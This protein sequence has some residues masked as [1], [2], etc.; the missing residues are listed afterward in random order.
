MTRLKRAELR[1]AYQGPVATDYILALTFEGGRALLVSRSYAGLRGARDQTAEF[2]GFCRRLLD[3]ASRAAPAAQ[4]LR[5]PSRFA[6]ALI[7]ALI[8]LGAGSAATILFAAASGS[9]FALGLDLGARLL[10]VML[11]LAS[12]LP[13][14]ADPRRRAFDPADLPAE[15]LPRT[16]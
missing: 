8:L 10:F 5:G 14:V 9:L 12:A 15:I 11:L 4:F 1:R 2:A 16:D 6:S 3:L 7:W 13:W